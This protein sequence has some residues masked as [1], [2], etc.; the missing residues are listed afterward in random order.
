MSDKELKR[1]Q[2]SN[3]KIYKVL[4]PK[5]VNHKNPEWIKASKGT[6]LENASQAQL[7]SIPRMTYKIYKNRLKAL[8]DAWMNVFGGHDIHM[9]KNS[10]KHYLD[11]YMKEVILDG[12]ESFKNGHPERFLKRTYLKERENG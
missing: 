10:K 11:E 3:E 6:P 8:G 7:D 5:M 9:L 12:A 4:L 1:A 2:K